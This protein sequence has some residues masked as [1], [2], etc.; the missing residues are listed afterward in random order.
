MSIHQGRGQYV[1]DRA[2]ELGGYYRMMLFRSGRWRVD[3]RWVGVGAA[4]FVLVLGARQT[5]AGSGSGTFA[6]D[7]ILSNAAPDANFGART[8]TRVGGGTGANWTGIWLRGLL[9]FTLPSNLAGRVTITSATLSIPTQALSVGASATGNLYRIFSPWT[10]GTGSG[11]MITGTPC[12]SAGFGATW[13]RPNCSIFSAWSWG[14]PTSSA[15]VPGAAGTASWGVASDVQAWFD[16]SANW[17]WLIQTNEGA[18]TGQRLATS[19]ASLSFTFA[20]KAGFV[21]VSNACSACTAA[22]QANCVQ[23]GGNSCVDPGSPFSYSCSCGNNAYVNSGSQFCVTKCAAQTPCDNGGDSGA[24]CSPNAGATNGYT[25]GCSTGFNFNGTTC[26]SDCNPPTS[27]PCGV[28]GTCS[29]GSPG[30]WSCSCTAGY[31]SSGGAR[32]SCQNYNGCDATANANCSVVNGNN[33]VDDA[34]P[35]LG[36]SCSC[37]NVAAYENGTSGGLPACVNRDDCLLGRCNDGGDNASTCTD[38]PAPGTGYVCNCSAPYWQP[39][40][41]GGNDSC[42]DVDECATGVN[43][44]GHGTCGNVGSGGGYRCVCDAGFV[45]DGPLNS[46]TCVNPNGCTADAQQLCMTAF[47]GNVCHDRPPPAI[48]YSCSCDNPAFAVGSGEQSCTNRNECAENKCTSEGDRKAACV[49]R[50]APQT[51]YE[52]QCSE[53]WVSDGNTCVDVNECAGQNP[54]GDHGACA[55]LKGRYT[56]SCQSGWTSDGAARPTCVQSSRP[57]E[58]T[59]VAGSLCAIGTDTPA[60]TSLAF[61][62]L[63]ALAIVVA[64]RSATGSRRQ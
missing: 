42:V 52:C 12:G 43:P 29:P 24:S 64:R 47:A 46:P 15:T 17:G 23:G 21:E 1:F 50:S 41:V 37:A 59:V 63:F 53:G 30:T 25:C 60:A 51:G 8:Y 10:E 35:S 32:P 7:S 45:V 55:N 62:L 39:G 4:L 48:G 28:G 38:T 31:V 61:A 20:C 26:V 3:N 36:Y 49:D 18:G 13:N 6:A 9:R 5:Y 57:I 44:C 33:C 56:C 27:N 2:F 58:V 14:G 19:S 54:C 16:G 40:L 22:A 34:P 11:S